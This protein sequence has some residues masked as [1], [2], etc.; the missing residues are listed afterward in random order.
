MAGTPYADKLDALVGQIKDP[1][2]RTIFTVS[3]KNSKYPK[4]C[5]VDGSLEKALRSIIA[6]EA[7]PDAGTNGPAH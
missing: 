1:F 6:L 4:D 5:I 7:R 2:L 3:Q